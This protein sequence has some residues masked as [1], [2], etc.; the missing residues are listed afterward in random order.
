LEQGEWAVSD[1]ECIELE[2]VDSVSVVKFKDKRVMDPTRIEKLGRE[3][4]IVAGSD[5]GK[6]LRVDF[7]NVKFISSAAISKLVV[8]EK[9]VRANGGK[10]RLSNLRP[11]VRD[12]FNMARLDSVF[13]IEE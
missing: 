4:D 9:R 6:K 11:E 8:F 2:N 12:V 10:L 7:D 3:L 1:F 13:E 5:Q